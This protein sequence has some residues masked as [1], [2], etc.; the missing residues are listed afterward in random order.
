MIKVDVWIAMANGYLDA[1]PSEQEAQEFVET[2]KNDVGSLDEWHI[3]PRT[4]RFDPELC[5]KGV[6]Q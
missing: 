1:F 4:V 3:V 5:Q 6:Q 2:Y